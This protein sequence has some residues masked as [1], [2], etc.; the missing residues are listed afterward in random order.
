M[1]TET[2]VISDLNALRSAG[3][4]GHRHSTTSL[5]RASWTSTPDSPGGLPLT[6]IHSMAAAWSRLTWAGVGLIDVVLLYMQALASL[7]CVLAAISSVLCRAGD[8]IKWKGV[9]HRDPR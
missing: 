6:C 9:G 4:T 5:L 8:M 1:N 2:D 7:W 3:F